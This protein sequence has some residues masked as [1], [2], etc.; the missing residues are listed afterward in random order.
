MPTAMRGT[1][2]M[3]LSRPASR[4]AL[5]APMSS[6][7]L[8]PVAEDAVIELDDRRERALSE[9]GDGA[10]SEFAVG[11]GDCELV[12]GLDGFGDAELEHQTFEQAAR[13]AGMAGR[14][15]A[16]AD[17]VVALRIAIE[18]RVEGD[19]AEDL[20][21]WRASGGGDVAQFVDAEVLARVVFLYGLEDSEE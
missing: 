16:D 4:T 8:I 13:S 19:D 5:K 20:R 6:M 11:C 17:G 7:R 21:E 14:A 18:E 9:A 3:T 2:G 15:A 1:A 12:G 10:H